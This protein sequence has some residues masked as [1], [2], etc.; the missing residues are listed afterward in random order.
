MQD[1][2]ATDE[3]VAAADAAATE[4][5]QAADEAEQVADAAAQD[6]EQATDEAGQEIAEAGDEAEAMAEDAGQEMAEAGDEAE[7]MAEDAGEEVAEE[8]GSAAPGGPAIERDGYMMADFTTIQADTLL[9]RG[10]FGVNDER[11]GDIGDIALSQDG[12]IEA[13]IVEVGGFL[14]IGEKDVALP[15]DEI[16]ILQSE[17]GSDIRVYVDYTEDELENMQE[18]G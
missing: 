17:D 4:A 5:D 8:T 9:D 7:A 3:A 12:A 15:F 18:A 2:D 13:V 1:G 6:V 10:I 16:T 14:G 11:I